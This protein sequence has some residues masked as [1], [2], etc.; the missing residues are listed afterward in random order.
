MTTDKKIHW[1]KIAPLASIVL[2]GIAIIGVPAAFTSAPAPE[3][4][5]A[6]NSEP[7]VHSIALAGKIEP[8]KTIFLSAPFEGNIQSLLVEH[9]QRV[10]Q[11]QRLLTLD[12]V[13]IETQLRDALAAQLKTR[14]VAQELKDWEN[15]AQVVRARR[16]VR[17]AEMSL[18]TVQRRLRD[19]R[20][21][22]ARGIIPRNELDDL[23]QQL[24]MQQLELTAAQN[25]L[26]QT[27]DQGTGEHRRIAEMEL[28]NA[29]VKH[30]GLQA[31]LDG[32]NIV[33]PFTGVIVPVTTNA[34]PGA[35][36]VGPLQ[37][38]TRLSQGQVVFGL[39]DIERLKIVAMVSELDI[40]Q[41]HPGQDVEIEGDGFEGE[42][43]AGT[44]QIVSGLAEPND[45]IGGSAKFSVTLSVPP[46]TPEQLQRV[47][48]GMSARLSITTY[49]N[50]KA[51][52][53]PPHAIRQEGPDR[54]VDY[55]EAMD[56]PARPMTVTTGRSTLN[57]VEVFGLAPGFVRA[58][59]RDDR[60]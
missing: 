46:L 51:I 18:G 31:L 3:Q 4:W 28:K 43:L 29:T 36:T 25:E 60:L 19:A 2:A 16:T 26:Q 55:R 48:L 42:R 41:L 20:Q 6:V 35:G 59:D 15:S 24:Q 45:E 47:R 11:G 38:G 33:A 34:V 32:Q 40:N 12:S 57:G 58:G 37:V 17:T 1:Q 54:L 9:G 39:A 30:E 56:Q 7:L 23:D 13:L 21:L 53:V 14:R 52:I 50:E 22:L 49:R 5:L 10:E 44:V 27:L 8:Q